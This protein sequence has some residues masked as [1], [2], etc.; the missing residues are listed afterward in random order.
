[1]AHPKEIENTHERG[2]STMIDRI[3]SIRLAAL[4]GVAAMAAATLVGLTSTASASTPDKP[5]PSDDSSSSAPAKPGKKA[6]KDGVC[7][8]GELCLF[9]LQNKVGAKLDLFVSDGD[10][11]N[12]LL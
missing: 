10:F 1:M 3:Q 9:Y 8:T 7:N 6:G 12:D 2:S 4:V 11:S 5:G